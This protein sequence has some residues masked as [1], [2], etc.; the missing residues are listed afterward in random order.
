MKI[1]IIGGGSFAWT[2]S[3]IG[4]FLLN[5]FFDGADLCLMDINPTALDEVL[6]RVKL[7]S[8]QSGVKLNFSTTTSLKEG[9]RDSSYV[10][11]AVAVGGMETTIRDHEIGR[12]FGFWNIKGHDIGPAGF[13][14]TL[15]HAPFLAHTARLME[16]YAA[17]G[18]MVL[19]VTN[20]LVANTMAV[21]KN[22]T[23]QAYGFCHGV[24]NHLHALLPIL[25]AESMDE[26]EYITTGIDHCSWLLDVKVNG[27]DALER[28]RKSGV[29]EAAYR[30]ETIIAA[31]DPFA[32]REAERLRFVIWD[33]LGY[34]PAISDDHI[35]EFLPQFLR[36]R[37][38]S[39]HWN[40][41]YDRVVERKKT[42]E[43][44]NIRHKAI[45]SGEI[46]HDLAPSGEI[47]AQA[48]AAFHGEGAFVS[49]M[50][51]PNRGQI[52]NLP[53][54]VIAETK[55]LIGAN[56][57]E[58]ITT[59]PLPDILEAIVRPVVLHE[60]LY[61]EAAYEWNKE[62]ALAALATDPIVNDFVSAKDMVDK[63]F[64]LNEKVLEEIGIQIGS[65]R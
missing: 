39:E 13:S 38:I 8:D 52:P 23:I 32:G 18:A 63:Y 21:Y 62:K 16:K 35:C 10:I 11:P 14:R 41:M 33:Q 45:L 51:A 3:L 30:N 36:T 22:T 47:I 31:D 46:K 56:G 37:E 7:L 40:M 4:D 54:G 43:S 29:I 42:I 17:P 28:M 20:P 12:E 24:H 49:V 26:V 48:I 59:G 50:N 9:V 55:C 25:G 5:D 65:W 27:K 57:V 64:E 34:L 58:P 60:K 15:R 19:N 61:M 53:D 6:E 44:T 1:T 2:P